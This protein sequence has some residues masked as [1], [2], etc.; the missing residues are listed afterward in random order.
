MRVVICADT[1]YPKLDGMSTST[2]HLAA[3]LAQQGHDVL[4]I[5]P[6]PNLTTTPDFYLA[7]V[8]IAW[9][10]SIP[11]GFYP[12]SRLA[13]WSPTLLARLNDFHPQVVHAMAPLPLSVNGLAY[14]RLR[15]LPVVMTFHTYFMDP[16]YLKVINVQKTSRI[17]E[18]LG[19]DLA[20]TIY[21]RAHVIIA[22]T[23]FVAAD[24]KARH[25][26]EP[27]LTIPNGV[28]IRQPRPEAAKLAALRTRY[29]LEG[30]RVLLTAGRVS[31]EKNLDG[32][33]NVFEQVSQK[34]PET[35][36]LIIGDGPQLADLQKRVTA[37]AALQKRVII[38]GG[39]AH[40]QLLKDGYYFLGEIFVT[41]S[42]TETQGMT[43]LEAQCAGLPV[44]AYQAKGL[45]FVIG[46]AGQ[47]VA[48]GDE[49]AMAQVIINLLENPD[50]LQ[51]LK[52]QLAANVAR[53]D[54]E[55]TTRQVAAAYE[56][57]R[58]IASGENEDEAQISFEPI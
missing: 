16:E 14:A 50:Q 34:L 28:V 44:V 43:C 42:Q 12:E 40:E 19:W 37:N 10:N 4:V 5:A 30:K 13:S 45:P 1:F 51:N 6:K 52:A 41:A 7:G 35:C 23:T 3:A 49:K 21:D 56:R 53:F 33:L 18:E 48:A 36:L 46:Q 22:P 39:I 11:A 25:F 32:L 9:Q 27:I 38:T 54:L 47:L 8:D 20:K 57:A 24:L 2:Q 26:R 29:Q 55:Q 17:I 31:L 58:Q 15:R